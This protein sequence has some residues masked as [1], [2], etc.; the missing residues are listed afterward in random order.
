MMYERSSYYN[1]DHWVNAV[2]KGSMGLRQF[3]KGSEFTMATFLSVAA[4]RDER[5]LRSTYLNMLFDWD[6]SDVKSLRAIQPSGG[7]LIC[8]PTGVSVLL[9]RPACVETTAAGEKAPTGTLRSCQAAVEC[10]WQGKRQQ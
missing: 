10:F 1:G 3:V 5:V 4:C 2:G 9:H 8:R 7:V 6:G